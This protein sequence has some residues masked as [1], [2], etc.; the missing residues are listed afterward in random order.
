MRVFIRDYLIPWL[1]VPG[2][3]FALWTLSSQTRKNLNAVNLFIAFLLL[4]PFL[5]VALHFVGK[6]LERYG[7][8]QD[9]LKRL[10]EI[11]EKTHGRLYFSKEINALAGVDCE[12]YCLNNVTNR[13]LG[14]AIAQECG[15]LPVFD[16]NG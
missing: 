2:S 14:E 8:S 4:I 6:A 7:Y 10:P 12:C 11:I 5:L 13:V 3:W 1:L 9:D 16:G 15:F